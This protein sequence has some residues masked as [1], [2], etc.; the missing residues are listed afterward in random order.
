MLLCVVDTFIILCNRMPNGTNLNR[1]E[2]PVP[3]LKTRIIILYHIYML[4]LGTMPTTRRSNAERRREPLRSFL[5]ALSAKTEFKQKKKIVI[6][7]V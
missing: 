6:V 1:G 5:W 3:L 4:Y 2:H 7:S